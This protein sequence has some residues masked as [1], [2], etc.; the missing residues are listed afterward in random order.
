MYTVRRKL[1]FQFRGSPPPCF[2]S[3]T[4]GKRSP[5]LSLSFFSD[6]PGRP[7]LSLVSLLGAP[8]LVQW[9]MPFSGADR[10]PLEDERRK[11]KRIARARAR[12]AQCEAAGTRYEESV[13][14]RKT[15]YAILLSRRSSHRVISRNAELRSF[16]TPGAEGE[17]CPPRGEH[18]SRVRSSVHSERRCDGTRRTAMRSLRLPTR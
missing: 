3:T 4:A 9:S 5:L 15:E 2:S 1:I 6:D 7:F 11:R 8:W 14:R 18:T 17:V 16:H 12:E 13:M 10:S